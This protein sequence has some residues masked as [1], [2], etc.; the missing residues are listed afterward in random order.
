MLRQ[1]NRMTD[2]IH[3]KENKKRCS[4]HCGDKDYSHV[5]GTFKTAL[6]SKNSN[7]FT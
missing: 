6:K 3:L 4:Y 2:K 1:R 5:Q 7:H